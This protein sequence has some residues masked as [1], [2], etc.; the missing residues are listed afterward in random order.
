MRSLIKIF[1]IGKVVFLAIISIVI[2]YFLKE[3]LLFTYQKSNLVL[4]SGLLFCI[5]LYY[6]VLI[7]KSPSFNL[8]LPFKSNLSLPNLV[9][10]ITC[11]AI[12]FLGVKEG[13][14]II[15]KTF[16]SNSSYLNLYEVISLSADYQKFGL[17]K[18]GLVPTLVN[19]ISSDYDV[20]IYCTTLIGLLLFAGG[21]TAVAYSK[22][23]SSLHGKIFLGIFLL[24]PIG[25]YNQFKFAVGAYDMAMIG[26]FFFA[27][28]SNKKPISL[29]FD[30]LGSLVHEA[31]FFLRLPFLLFNLISAIRDKTKEK[32][33]YVFEL[34]DL[35][36]AGFTFLLMSSN[37]VRPPLAA[38]KKNYFQHFSNLPSPTAGDFHAL[39]PLT[40]EGTLSYQL[41]IMNKYH[42][43]HEFYTY[44][45]PLLLSV[46][47]IVLINYFFNN[48]KGTQKRLDIACSLIVYLFPVL[49]SIIGTDI[50]RWMDF[51]FISWF[52]YYMIFRPKLFPESSLSYQCLLGILFTIFIL[53]PLGVF[54]HPLIAAF[55]K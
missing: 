54:E 31:Y 32:K 41:N 46:A 39:D 10:A 16:Q 38:L 12:V 13:L 11:I 33:S 15:N 53:S 25:I 1:P 49:L 47:A 9:L 30:V 22:Q 3:Y 8:H 6:M 27:T 40:K 2:S 20:Q 36:V 34:V 50:G 37:S 19:L 48:L 4:I 35:M 55:M 43:S 18:R 51:G 7:E 17:V 45:I 42:H 26:I 23:F 44:F 29:L 52:C 28:A 24:A 21:T 14:A 5:F